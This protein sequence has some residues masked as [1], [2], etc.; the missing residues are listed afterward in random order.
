MCVVTRNYNAGPRR[1]GGTISFPHAV[2]NEGVVSAAWIAEVLDG[3]AEPLFQPPPTLSNLEH[4]IALVQRCENRMVD[5]VRADRN[6]IRVKR[7]QFVPGH[8]IGPVPLLGRR[9]E[10]WSCRSH[11]LF[12]DTATWRSEGFHPFDNSLDVS[13]RRVYHSTKRLAFVDPEAAQAFSR[14]MI[15][16]PLAALHDSWT[17]KEGRGH[18]KLLENRIDDCEM[19][20]QP[21]VEG[22]GNLVAG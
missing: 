7:S 22:Q 9:L 13:S 6:H 16:E 17:N 3:A 12:H 20:T 4:D 14:L 10:S 18:A 11:R 8:N 2:Q 5:G 15:P 19:I 21:I 1:D